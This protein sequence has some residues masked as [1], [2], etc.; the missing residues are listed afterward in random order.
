MPRGGDERAEGPVEGLIAFASAVLLA[1]VAAGMF[2]DL[3]HDAGD[4]ARLVG[5]DAMGM[6]RT[7]VEVRGVVG[8]ILTG[9]TALDALNVTIGLAP[10]S[11]GLDLATLVVD[12]RNRTAARTLMRADAAGAG[13][14]TVA[15]VRD[16]DGSIASRLVLNRDDLATL[17]ANLTASMN[18]LR[19]PPRDALRILL[20]PH[21]GAP[22]RIDLTTP[23]TYAGKTIV[24]LR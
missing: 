6:T 23:P 17:D 7:A 3:G 24:T 13:N 4:R 11:D 19:L 21:P 16:L 2:L 10:G 8:R 5:Q 15:A 1:T 20:E 12:L 14:F 18:D 22:V 9:G